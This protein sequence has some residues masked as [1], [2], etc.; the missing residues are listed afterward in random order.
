MYG[1]VRPAAAA[2]TGSASMSHFTG[3]GT[4]SQ[5][6]LSHPRILGRRCLAADADAT[7]PASA[8][9]QLQSCLVV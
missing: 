3:F 2:E 5:Q 6:K 1:S 7:D 4:S 8:R 9:H